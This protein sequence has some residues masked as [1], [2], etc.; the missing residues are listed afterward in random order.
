[1][2]TANEFL[3]VFQKIIGHYKIKGVS[4][5]FVSRMCVWDW[6]ESEPNAGLSRQGVILVKFASVDFCSNEHEIAYLLAHEIGHWVC[7]HWN[8][9]LGRLQEEHEADIFAHK[10]LK[11]LGYDL[12]L[13]SEYHIRC[14]KIHDPVSDG[15]RAP[16]FEQRL[17]CILY[18]AI[19]N[20]NISQAI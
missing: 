15:V 20:E 5:E 14:T 16:T 12:D 13:A 10:V 1:M 11:E 2:A 4:V 6:D 3:V 9:Q 17:N 18:G 19:E 7:D 8:K